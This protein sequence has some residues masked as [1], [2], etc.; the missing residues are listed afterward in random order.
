MLRDASAKWILQKIIVLMLVFS[1]SLAIAQD[2]DDTHRLATDG[3]AEH[4][5]LGNPASRK[6]SSL[7][8]GSLVS[9]RQRETELDQT[10]TSG[11]KIKNKVS[12]ESIHF[13]TLVD[14]GAGAGFGVSNQT[15]YKEIITTSSSD[16]TERREL[17]KTTTT[18]GSV[19]IELTEEL[20]V[21][22]AIRGY[23]KEWSVFGAPFMDEGR[24]TK[25]VMPTA[26]PGHGV[27]Y[28]LNDFGASWAIFYPLRGKS[29]IQGE[30]FLI[31]E[32]GEVFIDGFY[33]INSQLRLG[34]G[35]TRWIHETDERSTGTTADDDQTNISLYGMDL[36][37]YVN[38]EQRFEV[39]FDYQATNQIQLRGAVSQ[40]T[41][42][43]HFNELE[44][45]N[46][47]DARQGDDDHE[48]MVYNRLKVM[49]KYSSNN[50]Q[51]HLG[52]S[53]YSKKHTFPDSLN[54][55]VYNSAVSEQFL[56]VDIKL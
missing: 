42:S 37:Q 20:T 21:A 2:I 32:S 46:G 13:G 43:F 12:S 49:M 44:R 26:A 50:L 56:T 4:L 8:G 39:A 38:P 23:Y 34:I 51:V 22:F 28:K 16:T 7:R 10:F 19:A 14:L 25:Y 41:D 53:R 17:I 6:F 45:F 18:T 31:V 54:G 33:E 1:P 15:N 3:A 11:D 40:Q 35:S 30:E 9:S 47:L 48:F 27:D 5:F 55:G 29:T 36:D 52:V 24:Q